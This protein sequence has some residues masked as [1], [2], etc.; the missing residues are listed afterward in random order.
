MEKVKIK[1]LKRG[2]EIAG[3]TSGGCFS[4]GSCNL[5][6]VESETGSWKIE[7]AL[8]FYENGEEEIVAKN[9]F[10]ERLNIIRN[11]LR[12]VVSKC[13]LPEFSESKFVTL[14]IASL[15]KEGTSEWANLKN[16]SMG[17]LSEVVGGNA[18]KYF[19]KIGASAVD[20]KVDLFN[21]SGS[22]ANQLVAIYPNENTEVPIQAFI[23]TRV[24]PILS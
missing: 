4:S 5:Y 15:K 11:R 14:R 23:V 17:E 7:I 22:S 6:S 10:P 19:K 13:D 8:S 16:A 9:V 1:V 2:L 18:L 21:Q 24:L 3:E 20:Y 12:M